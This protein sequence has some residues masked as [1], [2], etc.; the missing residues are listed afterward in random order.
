MVHDLIIQFHVSIDLKSR[1]PFR[2]EE[3]DIVLELV[4]GNLA[5]GM[6]FVDKEVAALE[7]DDMDRFF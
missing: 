1:I 2:I 3:A 4:G 5:V 6:A 7:F